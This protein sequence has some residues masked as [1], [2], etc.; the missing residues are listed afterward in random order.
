MSRVNFALTCAIYGTRPLR[1]CQPR[2]E[3]VIDR[4]HA[5]T[6]QWPPHRQIAS[7]TLPAVPSSPSTA[8]SRSLTRRSITLRH[9]TSPV[10]RSI[11][12]PADAHARHLG[13][14]LALL[15][16]A[17]LRR[18]RN[19]PLLLV[20]RVLETLIPVRARP[21]RLRLW[22]A[23]R[24]RP[25][26]FHQPPM[27]LIQ[28]LVL[29]F[30][31]VGGVAVRGVVELDFLVP[32]VALSAA[33]AVAMACGFWV[34]MRVVVQVMAVR[35]ISICHPP[36]RGCRARRLLPAQI[37]RRTDRRW[38]GRV[39]DGGCLLGGEL[40]F[41]ATLGQWSDGSLGEDGRCGVR[42]AVGR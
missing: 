11:H 20:A 3:G 29:R 8:D 10:V 27:H 41:E 35:C 9:H 39:D 37:Q 24:Q 32:A 38:V 40:R 4:I 21:R 26:G 22:C 5:R 23:A 28:H 14:Q 15:V 25:C 16:Q 12:V 31:R 17:G 18:E 6:A 7:S 19:L 2:I 13:A 42:G 34:L 1:T 33:G 30:S 36:L